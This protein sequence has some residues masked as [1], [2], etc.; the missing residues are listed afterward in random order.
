MISERRYDRVVKGGDLP[1]RIDLYEYADTEFS[2][3]W[4]LLA[5]GSH[6]AAKFIGHMRDRDV[7]RY[8]PDRHIQGPL[9]RF[10]RSRREDDCKL[11]FDL[12]CSLGPFSA[13]RDEIGISRVHLAGCL[14]IVFIKSFRHFHDDIPDRLLVF[15]IV[16]G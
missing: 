4:K 16:L 6:D 1:D 2:M 3:R 12:A 5:I 13:D 9:G 10:L 8:K 14:G 15:S 11:P 7:R